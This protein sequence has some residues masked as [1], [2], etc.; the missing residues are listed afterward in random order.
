MATGGGLGLA[1]AALQ[2]IFNADNLTAE[3]ISSIAKDIKRLGASLEVEANRV[4]NFKVNVH[5]KSRVI[6]VPI[7]VQ[8]IKDLIHDLSVGLKQKVQSIEQ[9]FITFAHDLKL[10]GEEVPD[11]NITRFTHALDQVQTFV[12][13]LNILVGEVANALQSSLSLT[14]LFD[15]VINDLEHLED[16]FLKQSSKREKK[17]I[18][19]YK[20]V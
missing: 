11:P 1:E 9:P 17:T 10:I 6:N 16:L 19:Y 3:K 5:W 13:Q 2:L 4:K 14:A 15:R 7:A 12:T 18:T 20:R 8:N